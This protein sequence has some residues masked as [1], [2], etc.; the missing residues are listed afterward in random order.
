MSNSPA[1]RVGA[2]GSLLLTMPFTLALLADTV[3]LHVLALALAI[4]LG[5]QHG[6][7]TTSVEAPPPRADF[8]LVCASLALLVALAV[9]LVRA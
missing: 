1:R 8:V 4:A 6:L 5:V 7:A 9:A 2:S 3:P